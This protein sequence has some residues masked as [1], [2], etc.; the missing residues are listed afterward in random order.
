L[1]LEVIFVEHHHTETKEKSDHETPDLSKLWQ[2]AGHGMRASDF[3]AAMVHFYRGEISRANLWRNRLDTT[4]NWAVVTTGA[5]LTFTFGNAD[6]PAALIIINTL[7]VLLFLLIEARRYR[8]YELWAYRVRLMETNYYSGLL[9][10]PFL[11]DSDWAEKL[12]ESLNKPSFPISLSEAF[13]RRYRRNYAFMFFILAIGWVLKVLIH[14]FPA[15]SVDQFLQNAAVGPIP[16]GLM[17]L[18]GVAVQGTLLAIGMATTPLRKSQGEVFGG[19]TEPYERFL[20]QLR[21]VTWESLEIDLPL[22]LPIHLRE[23]LVFIISDDSATISQQVMKEVHRGLTRLEGTGMFTGQPHQI[24]MCV[25]NERQARDIKR[26][27]K[28]IDEKAFVIVTDV[29]DVRGGGFRPLE[30]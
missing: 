13:G 20:S 29:R 24:L 18:L 3:N 8:Y 2:F 12:T 14:P 25:C 15:N 16:G 9:A 19:S 27:V 6:N 5:A 21:Q 17:I 4:T 30:A 11:P 10:P 26:I 22:R 7:L 1:E 23:Q 28:K